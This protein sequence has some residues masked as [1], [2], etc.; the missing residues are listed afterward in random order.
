MRG[1][2]CLTKDNFDEADLKL[3]D[4]PYNDFNFLSKVKDK[5]ICKEKGFG[6]KRGRGE[7]LEKLL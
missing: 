4:F 3:G 2:M 6:E 7:S 1:T 5:I